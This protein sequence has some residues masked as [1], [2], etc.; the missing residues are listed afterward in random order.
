M[1]TL[2]ITNTFTALAK[3]PASQLNQNFTDVKNFVNANLIHKDGSIVA[4]AHLS[5]PTTDPTTNPQY[6]NK[7]YVDKRVGKGSAFYNT[8]SVVGV[9][10]VAMAN[11]LDTGTLVTPT[12]AYRMIVKIHLMQKNNGT[13]GSQWYEVVFGAG[14][15]QINI[16]PNGT[17]GRHVAFSQNAKWEAAG[18][19]LVN[20]TQAS[21]TAAR[22][23]L[24]NQNNDVFGTADITAV[25]ETF[26]IAQ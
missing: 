8:V 24:R 6:A 4:S 21:G 7:L 2:N 25:A 11:L 5:G 26:I 20:T 14:T 13:D 16:E 9:N 18:T 15:T 10:N 12:F 22:W 3:L 19:I 1:A 17:G 23:R